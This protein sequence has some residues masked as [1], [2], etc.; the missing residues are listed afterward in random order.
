MKL[1]DVITPGFF[2]EEQV[3]D[4]KLTLQIK[5]ALNCGSAV[6]RDQD[7]NEWYFKGELLQSIKPN[8]KRPTELTLFGYTYLG[9]K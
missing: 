6:F 7:K 5:I 9:E 2:G 4:G 1:F 8:I 3:V